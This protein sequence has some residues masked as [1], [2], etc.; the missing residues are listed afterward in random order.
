[1]AGGKRPEIRPNRSPQLSQLKF[2][3]PNMAKL[4]TGEVLATFW[5]YEEGGY[6]IRW[7]KISIT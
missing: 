3:Y 2:G 1:M 7:I 5:C 4:S 6:R